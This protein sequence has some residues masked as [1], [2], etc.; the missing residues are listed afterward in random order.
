MLF[1]PLCLIW[2]QCRPLWVPGVSLYGWFPIIC[3][4]NSLTSHA[5][6]IHVTVIWSWLTLA[7]LPDWCVDMNF[8]LQLS[9]A[10]MIIIT[11]FNE[12]IS[13]ISSV[14]VAV[15]RYESSLLSQTRCTLFPPWSWNLSSR[16]SSAWTSSSATLHLSYRVDSAAPPWRTPCS[17]DVQWRVLLCCCLLYMENSPWARHGT[18]CLARIKYERIFIAI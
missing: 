12:L 8:S 3:S 6:L 10:I 2:C 13:V 9:V 11:T 1:H 14:K 16:S 4:P 5:L 18:K 7:F 17:G 15:S